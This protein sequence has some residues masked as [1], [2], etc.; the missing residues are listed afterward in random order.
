M[1][2][3]NLDLPMNEESQVLDTPDVDPY[4]EEARN[5]GWKPKEEFEG[6]I[7][8]WRPAKEFAERGELFSKIDSMGRELKETRKAMRLLQEHN[9]QIKVA[10]Y[11]N[12]L[13]ELKALQK[14]HLEE[15]NSDGYLE[16]SDIL[17]DL[18]AEQKAREVIE[19]TTVPQVDPRFAAWVDEN[20]WYSTDQEMRDHADIIGQRYAAQN[21][22][23]SPM[24]VLKVVTREIR[25]RFKDKFT[26]P[27]RNKPGAVSGS[28]TTTTPKPKT[29]EMTE[30]E[31]RVMNTFV[32]TGVMSKDEYISQLKLIRGEV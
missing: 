10:E 20:K 27:N 24:N 26:N 30:D 22:D 6:D 5:Q 13:K 7:S 18:K 3:E 21:P 11:N 32:R 9:S 14:K 4:E 17:S 15:G 29:F 16:T 8:K 2:E 12:A 1:D 28:D 23:E 31:R 25:M 19:E